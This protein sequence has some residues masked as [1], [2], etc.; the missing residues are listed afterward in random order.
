MAYFYYRNEKFVTGYNKP[1]KI[2]PSTSRRFATRVQIP[3][4]F[5]L[6]LIFASLCV[7]SSVQNASEQFV[8]CIHISWWNAPVIE[9]HKKCRKFKH[10]ELDTLLYDLFFYAMTD[11]TTFQMINI[12]SW[13]T[14]CA[15]AI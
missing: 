9:P 5:S 14:L 4:L 7:G 11:T 6:E 1:S 10:S 12:S 8:S 13:I 3:H 15:Y 2:P